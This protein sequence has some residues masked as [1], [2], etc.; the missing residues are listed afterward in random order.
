M[1][2]RR[3]HASVT[4][5][6]CTC[7]YLQRAADDPDVPI[8]F[9]ASTGEYQFIY[10]A[11][12][13]GQATL[14]VFHCPFCGGAAPKSKREQLFHVVSNA[15]EER[16]K[17]LLRLIK[18]IEDALERLGSPDSDTPFASSLT[19]APE[20]GEPARTSYERALEYSFL[21]ETVDVSII[22]GPGGRVSFSI[23]GKRKTA[24]HRN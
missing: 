14:I 1:S 15:E 3:T 11:E 8:R 18:T 17:E 23:S 4:E 13:W 2:E 20:D 19:T 10:P 5:V 24:E 22:E 12:V 21:S 6:D 9:E 16:L 7:E